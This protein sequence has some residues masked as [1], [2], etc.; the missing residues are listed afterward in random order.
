MGHTSSDQHHH[1]PDGQREP[2]THHTT[3]HGTTVRTGRPTPARAE[4]QQP[5]SRNDAI[6]VSQPTAELAWLA[7]E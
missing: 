7:A 3:V 4:G 6:R 1:S 2:A 5:G